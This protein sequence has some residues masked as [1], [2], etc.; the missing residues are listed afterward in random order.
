MCH[1]RDYWLFCSPPQSHVTK[2][3]CCANF[4]TSEDTER[5]TESELVSNLTTSVV[6]GRGVVQLGRQVC[7]AEEVKLMRGCPNEYEECRKTLLRTEEL[8]LNITKA[9]SVQ[10]AL[11]DKRG[12]AASSAPYA[13]PSSAAY[14][15][16]SSAAHARPSSAA[17]ARPS[18]TT[19]VS[20]KCSTRWVH[21]HQ[22]LSVVVTV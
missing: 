14:A 16:P 18:S 5:Q 15:R 12:S 22:C 1:T 13:R 6:L 3:E 8:H 11:L 21:V 4:P 9:V 10:P 2:T 7:K 17:H 19:V 20:H